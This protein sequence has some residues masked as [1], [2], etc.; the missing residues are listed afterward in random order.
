M[1]QNLNS[2][3][4][5]HLSSTLYQFWIWSKSW[6]EKSRH[7]NGDGNGKNM[8]NKILTDKSDTYDSIPISYNL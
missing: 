6:K 1:L 4:F 5:R 8:N 3:K 2:K 7:A